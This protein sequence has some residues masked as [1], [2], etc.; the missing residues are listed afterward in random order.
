M[1]REAIAGL[2]FD[3]YIKGRR[4]TPLKHRFLG[5]APTGFLI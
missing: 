2:D 1:H 3:H 5:A 4:R